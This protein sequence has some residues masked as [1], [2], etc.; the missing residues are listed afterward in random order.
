M[1]LALGAE[2]QSRYLPLPL[3]SCENDGKWRNSTNVPEGTL[4]FFED[5]PTEINELRGF[6][7]VTACERLIWIWRFEIALAYVT[8]LCFRVLLLLTVLQ[9]IFMGLCVVSSAT[10]FIW[11]HR[12]PPNHFNLGSRKADIISRSFAPYTRFLI[13]YIC[14]K[15][16]RRRTSSNDRIARLS[17]ILRLRPWGYRNVDVELGIISQPVDGRH[18]NEQCSCPTF[19]KD[20]C[21][22][23]C[24]MQICNVSKMN[25]TGTV[26]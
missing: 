24:G 5:I 8:R 13:A 12:L 4:T 20:I 21:C 19:E 7:I 14:Q 11:F 9:R 1:C 2:F 26:T 25:H 6:H 15:S 22:W 17:H 23:G 18:N 16:R 3:G 10:I